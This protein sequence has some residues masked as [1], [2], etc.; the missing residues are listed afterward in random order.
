MFSPNFIFNKKGVQ[1]LADAVLLRAIRDK[2]EKFFSSDDFLFWESFLPEIELC[3]SQYKK[4]MKRRKPHGN[5]IN[6]STEE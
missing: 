5:T 4:A 1:N 2:D 6:K 3:P